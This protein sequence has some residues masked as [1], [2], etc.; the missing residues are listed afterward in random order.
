MNKWIKSVVGSAVIGSFLLAGTSAYAASASVFVN[1]QAQYDTITVEGRTLVKLRSLTDPKWLVFAYDSK[2]R[3]VMVHTKDNSKTVQLRE[4]EK[5]ATVNGEKVEIDAAVVNKNGL[6][7]VPLRFISESLGASVHYNAQEKRV[8]VRTPARQ[9][10][11]ETLMRG[12][13]TEAR[14]IALGLMRLKGKAPATVPGE[15]YHYNYYTFPEGEALRFTMNYAGYS[16]AYY[17]VNED[18]LAILKWQLDNVAERE[19]GTKPNFTSYVYFLD[20]FMGGVFTYGIVDKQ[21]KDTQ[22][23]RFHQDSTHNLVLPIK[24]EKRTDARP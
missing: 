13:L 14:G 3:I 15:G 11:Y 1:G 17:E 12:D 23:G 5:T 2:T 9:A 24:G 7:Y 20:E 10:Q 18:G 22:L 16:E 4:G 21:G 19:W 8:I 6:T